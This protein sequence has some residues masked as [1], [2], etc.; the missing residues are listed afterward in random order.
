M[1]SKSQQRGG[2]Q[3][4]AKAMREAE[5]KAAARK[6]TLTV[7]GIVVAVI[8]LIVAL[9]IGISASRSSSSH[10]VVVPANGQ[11]TGPAYAKSGMTIGNATAP[12]TMDAYEDF[13]CP[14]CGDFEK[15]AGSTVV[16]MINDGSL[17]VRYHM[18]DFIDTHNGGTYSLRAANAFAAA[19]SDDGNSRALAFHSGLYA[20]QPDESSKAEL[21]DA[22]IL[23][24]AAQAAITDQAFIAAVH[25]LRYQS[26]VSKTTD[27]ASKAGVNGTP[28]FF[29]NGKKVD[30][31]S[32]RDASGAYTATAFQN[33]VNA[34]KNSN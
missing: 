32:L 8:A 3:E 17:R 23:Q 10:P 34:A 5:R 15:A 11:L 16:S 7:S 29:L 9:G 31:N 33:V 19:N 25:N 22:K 13:N 2:R 6:R 28:T 30:D 1:V 14:V 20:N 21:S 18:M 12:M 4:R 26:W 27:N 24:I